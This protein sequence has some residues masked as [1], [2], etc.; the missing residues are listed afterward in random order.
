MCYWYAT[1]FATDVVL[2]ICYSCATLDVLLMC[3]WYATDVILVCYWC[4]TG[5]ETPDRRAWSRCPHQWKAMKRKNKT[6]QRMHLW[7]YDGAYRDVHTIGQQKKWRWAPSHNWAVT[8][9]SLVQA[10]RL[11]CLENCSTRWPCVVTVGAG[12]G[13]AARKGRQILSLSRRSLVFGDVLLMCYLWCAAVVL[14][15]YIVLLICE[16]CATDVLLMMYVLLLMC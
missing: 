15:V 12:Q 10:S 2:L 4:V 14:L 8:D 6:Q 13:I 7:K 5:I 11:K 9:F 16:W 1:E 3:Y